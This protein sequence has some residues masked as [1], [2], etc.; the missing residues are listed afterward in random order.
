MNRIDITR[1]L[2]ELQPSVLQVLWRECTPRILVVTDSL[3]YSAADGAG[4]SQFV[5]TLRASTIHGMTPIVTTASRGGSAGAQLTNYNFNDATNGLLKSRYDVLFLFGF[6]GEG[7]NDLPAT[8]VDTIERFMQDGGGVFATG[9]H[10]TLGASLCG[11][12]ARV[13][14]MRKW[15][16]AD[17]PPSASGTNRHSTNLSGLDETETFADQSDAFAQRLYLNYRTVAGGTANVDRA[18]HPLMRM[19]APRKVL[20]VFPDHPHEGECVLPAALGGTFTLAGQ[21]LPEWPQDAAGAVVAPEMVAYTVSHGDGF[22]GKASLVPRLFGAVAAYDGHRARVGRVVTDATWHH[23]VNI[24]LDGTGSGRSGFKTAL[25]ADTEELVRIRQYFVNLATWLM[26]SNVRRCLRFPRLIVEMQRFPLFEELDLPR[27]PEFKPELT[28]ALGRSVLASLDSRQPDWEAQ[29]L[30]D[31]VLEDALG[32]KL[33]ARLSDGQGV[34]GISREEL[35]AAAVGG[36][37]QGMAL[38][39]AELPSSERLV[40]HKS[41]EESARKGAKEAVAALM[42]ERRKAMAEIDEVIRTVGAAAGR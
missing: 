16:A 24:N 21:S 14:R 28:V 6:S 25:G 36:L 13:R 37:V 33:M 34:G 4:L 26:P 42:G 39:L 22:D 18:A 30:A 15:K 27:P 7:S 5:D 10:E 2:V 19:Q 35:R 38:E 1:P 40:P 32:E 9:D 23:F 31:D 17:A 3:N 12:I 11:N 41:F 8:Q 29:E 20:E